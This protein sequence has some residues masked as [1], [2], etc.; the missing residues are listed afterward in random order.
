MA[1]TAVDVGHIVQSHHHDIMACLCRSYSCL[2][3]AAC[4]CSTSCELSAT[5]PVINACDVPSLGDWCQTDE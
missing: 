3:V 5:S 4:S 2:S 1:A